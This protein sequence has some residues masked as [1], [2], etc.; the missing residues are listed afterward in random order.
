MNKE[1]GLSSI[2]DP[3]FLTPCSGSPRCIDQNCR[4][5]YRL[6]G[7]GW[8]SN[9]PFSFSFFWQGYEFSVVITLS[10]F[11]EHTTAC[12]VT[13][14]ILRCRTSFKVSIVGKKSTLYSLEL[15][16][17]SL[18]QCI[19]HGEQLNSTLSSW[20]VICWEKARTKSAHERWLCTWHR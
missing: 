3:L 6:I 11:N 5:A 20:N 18:C 8:F 15:Y 1:K 13:P 16:P 19:R 7:I 4:Q 14:L 12:W 9:S 17:Y 10:C 2:L